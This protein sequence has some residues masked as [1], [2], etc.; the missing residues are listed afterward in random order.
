M[1]PKEPSKDEPITKVTRK[2][3]VSLPRSL[4]DGIDIRSFSQVFTAPKNKVMLFKE[5][6]DGKETD[7]FLNGITHEPYIGC[8]L[9]GK[10]LKESVIP[11]MYYNAMVE[12]PVLLVGESGTGK[13]TAGECFIQNFA[14]ADYKT[15]AKAMETDISNADLK[16]MARKKTE[17]IQDETGKKKAK[18]DPSIEDVFDEKMRPI[19]RIQNYANIMKEEIVGEWNAIRMLYAEK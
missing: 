19:L 7:E 10:D 5:N 12:K 8:G 18:M 4:L 6:E 14:N 17:S 13:T 3:D 15:I 2:K 16:E 11:S 1:K 9:A